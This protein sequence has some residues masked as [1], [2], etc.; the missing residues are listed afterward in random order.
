MIYVLGGKFNAAIEAAKILKKMNLPFYICV[1]KG[2]QKIVALHS[3]EKYAK[4]EGIEII[5]SIDVFEGERIFFISVEYDKIIDT[6]RFKEDSLFFNIHFSL[7]PKYRGTMTSF[8]P[9]IFREKETGVTLHEIDGGID[10]GPIIAQKTFPIKEEYTCR[11]LY[12][13]YHE[14]AGELLRE[15]LPRLISGQYISTPQ[16]DI[17]ASS[18]PRFLYSYFPKEFLSKNLKLMEA[19]D[20][21]N[22]LRALIFEEYQLPIVDGRRISKVSFSNFDK[23][24]FKIPTNSGYLYAKCID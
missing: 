9:I 24:N 1:S 7:L 8:W 10:T 19:K 2:E 20:V 6:K 16:V 5:E 23:S 18:F 22:I 4:E 15:M 13:K 14:V 11:D 17:S 3:L 12:F 21:Y